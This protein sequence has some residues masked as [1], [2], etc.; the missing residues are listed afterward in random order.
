MPISVLPPRNEERICAMPTAKVGAPPVRERML[1]SP[2][3]FAIWVISA[4]VTSKPQFEI[5][6]AA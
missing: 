3:S 4:G 1:F 2:T 5:T 6:C